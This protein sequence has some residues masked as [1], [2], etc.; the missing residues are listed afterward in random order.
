MK[1]LIPVVILSIF[2]TGS[3]CLEKAL[4][5]PKEFNLEAQETIESTISL[6]GVINSIDTTLGQIKIET[7]NGFV[8]EVLI[9]PEATISLNT[10]TELSIAGLTVGSL[11]EVFGTRNPTTL[12]IT[13]RTI[14]MEDLT[15]VKII[16]PISGVTVTS[17]LIVE[18]FA[19]T[20]DQK[21]FWR[22]KDQNN[23]TQ[24]SGVNTVVGEEQKYSPFRLEIYLPA[25]EAK[26]LTLDIFTKQ[27]SI[28]VGLVTLPLNLLSINKSEFQIFLS[29]DLLNTSR[30][31]D[32]VFPVKRTVAETSAVGRASL[33]ELLNG[34]TE[35]EHYEGY[36]SSLPYDTIINSFVISNG[37]AVVTVSKNFDSLSSCEKQRAAE[38]IKQ[39]LMQFGIVDDVVIKV[40]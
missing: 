17:P 40:E 15:K 23:A 20:N 10:D 39:T 7:I 30:A 38:Q 11:A 31:C 35:S 12:V 29:S 26:N 18:G 28:E 3:G 13:A 4:E 37:Q 6:I 27:A 33:I 22:V 2:L 16:S 36:R 8:E 5:Y 19:K 9:S 14:R 34:P 32:V 21:I 24:L 25:L 1:R